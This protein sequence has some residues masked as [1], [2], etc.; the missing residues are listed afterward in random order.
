MVVYVVSH[1][2]LPP[3]RSLLPEGRSR[4]L[5]VLSR[6]KCRDYVWTDRQ[7]GGIWHWNSRPWSGTSKNVG[8]ITKPGYG[9][10][11]VRGYLSTYLFSYLLTYMD[12]YDI[13]FITKCIDRVSRLTLKEF[14]SLIRNKWVDLVPGRSFTSDLTWH[15]FPR[16][17]T[18]TPPPQ[19]GPKDL[20]RQ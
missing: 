13:A 4:S 3:Y 12:G 2:P 7:K 15:T 17:E 1:V 5:P 8:T 18:G 20:K 11:I 9:P 10:C 6:H 16:S 14:L 19:S